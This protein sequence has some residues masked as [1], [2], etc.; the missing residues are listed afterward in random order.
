M[1]DLGIDLRR[2]DARRPPVLLL[3]GLNLL[4]SLGLAHIP[5]IVASPEADAPAFASRYCG[6][7]LVLPA[8]AQRDAV[9]EALLR[10]GK[11][12]RDALGARL[13]LFYGD[14][15]YLGIVQDFRVPLSRYFLLALNDPAL[16]RVLMDKSLFQALAEAR[17]LPVPRR[18]GW[19]TLERFDGP[20]L[21]KPKSKQGWDQSEVQR[22]LFGGAGKARIFADGRAVLAD[23]R[24][25]QLAGRLVFQEYVPG[26]DRSIWSF[27]GFATESGEL[28]EWFTG[29]KIRTHP[30][31][32]GESSYLELERNDAL[33]ALGRKVVSRVALKGVFKIDFKQH[34]ASG[35]F[36]ILEIN[37]RFNLWHHLGA[38][39]GVNLIEVAYDWLTRGARPLHAE[40]KSTYR[41]ICLRLDYKAYRELSSRG[42]LSFAR[43]LRSLLESRKIYDLFSWSDARPFAAHALKKLKRLPRFA[44]RILRPARP[45]SC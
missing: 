22:R 8:L 19:D 17:G 23:P 2:I 18:L 25:R 37:A 44:W 4:R 40:A 30:T 24:A 20:V 42:E 1:S 43:W 26:G 34:A 6:A 31:L 9:V 39:N 28:L 14:D 16:G 35:D 13:P 45:A 32:T 27:H 5:A 12:A 38:R 11:S 7:R 41:W 10:A 29:R 15:D 33:A 3:G 36:R 21:V